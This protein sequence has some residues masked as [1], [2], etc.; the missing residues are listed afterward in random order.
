MAGT[1][2][3]ETGDKGTTGGAKMTIVETGLKEKW[4]ELQG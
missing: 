4:Q 3:V 2:G 1:T